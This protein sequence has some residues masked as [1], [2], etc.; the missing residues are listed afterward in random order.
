MIWRF[1]LFLSLIGYANLALATPDN[2]V[3]FQKALEEYRQQMQL[4]ALSASI[5]I[6]GK[7]VAAS[8][9]GVRKHG[10]SAKVKVDDRFHIGSITK[11]L[12][13]TL[14]AKLVDEGKLDWNDTI[15]AMFPELLNKMQSDYRQV[16]V[17][18][19]LRHMSGMPY[20]PS[21]PESKTDQYGTSAPMK[22]YGYVIAALKDK[23][24]AKPDH[25]YIYGGGQVIA[26]QHA[27]RKTQQSYENL[28]GQNLFQPLGM[29]TA[30]F[31]SP[32]NP[33]SIDGPWEHVKE[34]GQIKHRPPRADQSLQAR[35]PVG[36]NLVMSMT[37][38]G[39]FV[40]LHLKGARG[41]SRF[42]KP[43]TFEFIHQPD[44]VATHQTVTWATGKTW[45]AEGRIYWH[46]G[47]TLQNL[48]KCHIV[49]NENFGLCLATNIWYDGIDTPFDRMNIDIVKMIQ[50]GKFTTRK[51]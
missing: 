24:Q 7:V 40:A 48:A 4:P 27:E 43:K 50:Q 9:V 31:G 39:K 32:A 42:L 45:W 28:M 46:G 25:K 15:Q 29:S 17:T 10:D 11:T 6:G 34:K 47:S 19:L 49:P 51:N 36:R 14:I 16:T 35:S 1:I 3:W 41:E 18:Q 26:A 37:D 30:R 2:P 21:T 13:G 12:T 5:V 22:R 33:N 8:A 44:S 38:L 23:S 20:S